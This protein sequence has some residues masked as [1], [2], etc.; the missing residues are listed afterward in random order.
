MNSATVEAGKIFVAGT[1]RSGTTLMS[2]LLG[3]HPAIFRVPGESKF[4]VEG[5]GLYNLRPHLCENFSVT[6]SDLA[7]IRFIEAMGAPLERYMTSPDF[8]LSWKYSERIGDKYYFPPLAKFLSAV[9][10]FEADGFPFPKHF[11]RRE[12]LIALMRELVGT[13]FGGPAQD[14]KK[15]FWVEK[16]PA[17]I[18]A[19][20]F[21]WELFPE[22]SIIHIKRDP[23]GVVHSLMQ[24]SWA[25]SDLHQATAIV[26]SIYWRWMQLKER[27]DLQARKYIEVSLEDL[28]RT[29]ASVMQRIAGVI[30]VE[31]DFNLRRVEPGAADRWKSEMPL[32]SCRY[33]EGQLAEYFDIMGYDI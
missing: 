31:P 5:D 23:R 32:E 13:M 19:M 10:A 27:L 28:S 16:T 24:Q 22:A 33:C 2:A 14:A 30:G 1:G 29:P 17:N 25:P 6:S 12:D 4:I 21:L 20:D 11:T 3:S 26:K 8:A 15:R 7:L 18:L 9:T